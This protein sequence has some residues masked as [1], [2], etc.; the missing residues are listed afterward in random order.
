M[1]D[2]GRRSL[3]DLAALDAHQAVLDVIDPPDTVGAAEGV[4]AL[5]EGHRAEP[6]AVDGDRDATL[7]SRSPPPRRPARTRVDGPGEG[8][9]RRG[10]PGVLED[11]LSH[12]RPHMLTSMEYGEAFVIGISIP[13]ALA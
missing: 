13:R 4:E 6:I 11:A 10:D 12:E 9:G 5:D 3:V 1:E 2:R 8:V 7:R